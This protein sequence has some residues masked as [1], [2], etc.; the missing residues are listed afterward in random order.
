MERLQV[1]N[2]LDATFCPRN[3]VERV[4]ETKENWN[5]VHWFIRHHVFDLKKKDLNPRPTAEVMLLS[6]FGVSHPPT[7]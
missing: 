2:I 4:I 3:V 1:E 7:N 6:G 5:C